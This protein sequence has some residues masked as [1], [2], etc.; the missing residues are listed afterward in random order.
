MNDLKEKF[1]EILKHPLLVKYQ[2]LI[3]PV[4]S[5]LVCIMLVIFIIV[6]QIGAIGKAQ[7][8]IA[9]MQAKNKTLVQKIS[10][11]S[12]VD[13]RVN[14]ENID[15]LL[16]ALPGESDV[17][18]A[19]GQVLFLLDQ[20]KLVLE[21]ISFSSGPTGG[22]AINNFQIKLDVSGN[23]TG[24]KAFIQNLKKAPRLMTID[25]LDI[26]GG[27]DGGDM[28]GTVYLLVYYQVLPS[29]IGN[30]EAP[31]SVINDKDLTTIAQ[32]KSFKAA[33]PQSV[34]TVD[35]SVPRGKSDPFQ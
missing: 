11:L 31:V 13:E 33:T 17:P 1:S 10:A 19:I 14:R 23:V 4:A 32:I 28:Q 12:Q 25:K 6:P 2:V 35:L 24:I 5:L 8:S 3:L 20:S 29:S 22:T 15:T 34:D 21:S 26:A 7:E 16:S 30:V 27:R 9:Q 18:G